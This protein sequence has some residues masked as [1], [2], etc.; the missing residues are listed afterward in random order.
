M[1]LWYIYDLW[2][3]IAYDYILW[4]LVLEKK[5]SF[6]ILSVFITSTNPLLRVWTSNLDSLYF[7]DRIMRLYNEMVGFDIFNFEM[8]W[9]DIPKFL[10]W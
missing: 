2:Y 3:Y 5:W 1:V 8:S 6:D 10:T 4:H 7:D 9:I